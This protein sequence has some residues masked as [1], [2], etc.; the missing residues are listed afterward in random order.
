MELLREQ[1]KAWWPLWWQNTVKWQVQVV[2]SLIRYLV[3]EQSATGSHEQL[4]TREDSRDS[5]CTRTPVT[6]IA[7]LM[8]SRMWTQPVLVQTLEAG[9]AQEGHGSF[10]FYLTV[11]VNATGNGT[12]DLRIPGL[13]RSGGSRY[14]SGSHPGLL[15]GP[16]KP[17]TLR[18]TQE[19]SPRAA[20]RRPWHWA[21]PSCTGS[22]STR[23]A[24]T[25]LAEG[26]R[27]CRQTP[28]SL[29]SLTLL[30]K[31]EKSFFLLTKIFSG[32]SGMF[33]G[34]A[35]V[36][37]QPVPIFCLQRTLLQCVLWNGWEPSTSASVCESPT[38]RGSL[39]SKSFCLGKK[40]CFQSRIKAWNPTGWP[41]S[42]SCHCLLCIVMCVRL[43]G[44]ENSSQAWR[45]LPELRASVRAAKGDDPPSAPGRGQELELW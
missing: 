16:V 41:L 21:S 26:G 20:Q 23:Q 34:I 12:A 1:Q 17:T 38:K 9:G 5:T 24:G 45:D 10:D 11:L 7:L 4:Q 42:N 37:G 2:Q 44:S 14:L 22:S 39:A 29:W 13:S 33:I 31:Q 6:L 43:V 3:H 40:L 15:T 30:P 27:D 36:S 18:G 25:R 35:D 28:C 32:D 19:A 8:R